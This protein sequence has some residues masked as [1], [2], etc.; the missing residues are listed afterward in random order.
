[1]I[2]G[3][4]NVIN[5][6]RAGLSLAALTLFGG[7]AFA[8]PLV[9]TDAGTIR[10][11]SLDTTDVFMGVPFAKPPV[12]S[13]RWR[14]PERVVRWTGVRDA[15]RP[16][17]ICYQ[18]LIKA[19]DPYPANF[20]A[21]GP[22]S[23]DCLYL[24]VWKPSGRQAKLPVY[25]YIH[26]GAFRGGAGSVPIYDGSDLAAKGAVVVTINY[27][28]GAFGFLAHPDLARESARK[29]SGNYAI[30]DQIA[31]LRW[32]RA[33]I[34]RLGGDP[35]N[36]TVAGESAG[37][38][39]VNVLL[40]APLAK[41]L[42]Q[43]AVSMS[44]PVL[45]GPMMA[46]A[47][48]ENNGVEVAQQIGGGT[49]AGLRALTAEQILDATK[50]APP[51][52]GAARP[53]FSY[54]PVLDGKVIAADPADGANPVQVHVPL[55]AGYNSEEMVD[56]KVTTPATFK[57]AVAR[58]YGAFAD[59]F[60]ALYPH[61][62]DAEA[63]ASNLV[64]NRDRYMAALVLWGQPRARVSGQPVYAY[65]YDHPFPTR[66]SGKRFGAFHTSAQ[67]YIFGALT[68]GDRS[69]TDADRAIS[70]QLQAHW[71][72]FM[73][74]G[75]PAVGGR[76]WPPFGATSIDVMSIGDM[77]GS[78]PAVSSPDRLKLFRDFVAAGGRIGLI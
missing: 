75:N 31:A 6:I 4:A 57:A 38:A 65:L 33:N 39:S 13:L 5:P 17:A 25:V 49:L 54:A 74:T 35:A 76:Q 63:V 30:L 10:G 27:R 62:T 23:E 15:T 2:N 11:K 51:T 61:A 34:A 43:R 56:Y 47:D 32:V 16:S 50:G 46:V 37:A 77:Q 9:Q 53:S 71:L 60:L 58:R 24:N 70:R 26:G 12:G 3:R 67:P 19:W 1:M 8:Q 72:A 29:T 73:R 14:A 45:G 22:V 64:L 68:G 40:M 44:G 18:A 28:V 41:G 36:V 59:R 66:P 55:L 7:A 48:A 21:E 78:R 52:P 20:I 42:F 69:F